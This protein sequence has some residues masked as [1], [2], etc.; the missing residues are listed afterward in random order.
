MLRN[1][2]Y[3]SDQQNRR[4]IRRQR[5]CHHQNFHHCQVN[6]PHNFINSSI[7]IC[8]IYRAGSRNETADNLGVTHLLRNC[9]GLSTKNV[10]QFLITRNIQQV[11]ASLTA[12]SD[13]ETISYTLEGTKSAVDKVLPFL[14]E[15]ATQQVFKPWEVSDT[16][17]RLHLDIATR[18]L[19]VCNIKKLLMNKSISNSYIIHLFIN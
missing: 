5:I 7:N 3:H 13:R 12:T 14:T 16:I 17:P 2:I 18:P 9:A 4:S 11:G 10:S 1:Q 8:C 19:Q 6:L 15:V